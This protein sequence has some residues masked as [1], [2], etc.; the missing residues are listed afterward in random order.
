MKK[1]LVLAG[2]FL[3]IAIS[4][5]ACG[6]GSDSAQSSIPADA[7]AMDTEMKSNMVRSLPLVA[8][9]ESSLIFVMNP[10]TPMAQGV[11][12]AP[13]LTPGAP[14]NS[15]TFDGTYDGNGDGFKETT[16]SGKATFNSNPD[17]NWNGMNGQAAVN[18]NIPIVGHLYH[19]DI[20]YSITS[21]DKR[22]SGS[23]TFTNPLTGNVTTMA[24]AP[25]TPLVVKPATGAAGAVPNACGYS[26][27]GKMQLKVEGSTGTLTSNWNFSSSN[28]SVAVNGASFTDPS[29][30]TTALPD[31]TVDLRCGGSGTINDWVATY[32]QNYSCL[33]RETGQATLT[34]TATGPDT[35]T[36]SDED[37]PGSGSVNN[38]SAT[39]VAGNPH[40]V[41]GFFIGGPVGNRYREDF[42]WTLAKNGSSFSQFSVYTYT[43][44]PNTGSG[45]IC[46]A[47]AKRIP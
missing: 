40:A 33:P 9:I 1:Y 16:M 32:S 27:D 2:V 44:G 45:G 7:K 25:G 11:T 8:P 38:Y 43:E 3:V 21:T 37:P 17:I 10:N 34:L 35:I 14:P 36:I 47:S 19:A 13:D 24:A 20:A 5:Y 4:I 26:L 29:G 41:R 22:L 28:P 46:A 6:G 12:V 23:G 30:N 18:A 15:I 31:S 39:I 42:T